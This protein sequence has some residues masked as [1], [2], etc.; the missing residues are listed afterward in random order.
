[1]SLE[2]AQQLVEQICYALGLGIAVVPIILGIFKWNHIPWSRKIQYRE[3]KLL[4]FVKSRTPV[5]SFPIVDL[6]ENGRFRP[7]TI[8]ISRPLPQRPGEFLVV[9]YHTD[10]P[11]ALC[12]E[13][14]EKS[15]K[16]FAVFQ[17]IFGIIL[18]AFFL[19]RLVQG[20]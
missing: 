11:T 15:R 18:V 20:I 10:N 3:V 12:L 2:N 9:R 1:M 14:T 8:P 7:V 17:I 19:Y 13:P 16:Q 5:S 6:G 4:G